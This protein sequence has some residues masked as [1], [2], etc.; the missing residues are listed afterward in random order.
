MAQELDRHH[1]D[2]HVRERGW[3]IDFYIE[4]DA[5]ELVRRRHRTGFLGY[6]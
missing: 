3:Y 1:H 5:L 2:N 6:G 4:R